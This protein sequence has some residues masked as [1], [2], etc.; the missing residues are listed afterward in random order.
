MLFIVTPTCH[1]LSS[2]FSGFR[3]RP[4]D[5]RPV[6]SR[7]RLGG[8]LW[9]RHATFSHQFCAI[10]ERLWRSDS[11]TEGST[12]AI[13]GQMKD[14]AAASQLI[15]PL[16]TTWWKTGVNCMF[17]S[18]TKGICPGSYQ[19]DMTLS[20]PSQPM[21]AQLSFES[22]T[23]IGW[24][25]GHFAWALHFKVVHSLK[26][27]S[28]NY[29]NF[30]MTGGTGVFRYGSLRCHQWRKIWHHDNSRFSVSCLHWKCQRVLLC[31]RRQIILWLYSK[32]S[33]HMTWK[34]LENLIKFIS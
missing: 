19:G 32:Y 8:A 7:W 15:G 11:H 10:C 1:A 2:L 31:Q 12:V 33:P 14:A 25:S 28:C 16:S 23:V 26:T 30:L 18:C 5:S 21:A 6:T 22:C 20:Q 3:G 34:W 29:T 4:L 9:C 24:K 13:L 27:E 17:A